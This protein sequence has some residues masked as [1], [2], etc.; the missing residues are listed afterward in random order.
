MALL[1]VLQTS[2]IARVILPLAVMAVI[3]VGIGVAT[4]AIPASDGQIHGCYTKAGGALRVI[5][6]EKNQSCKPVE[7]PISW[8]QQ[9]PQG[10]P[11]PP[12]PSGGDPALWAIVR[13]ADGNLFAGSHVA[14]SVRNFEGSYTIVFDQSIPGQGGGRLGCA[15]NVTPTS[16]DGDFTTHTRVTPIV[17]A[18]SA[19]T[20]HVE[21]YEG[22]TTVDQSFSLAVSC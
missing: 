6:V 21:N 17:Y 3:S 12:G 19:T 20:I 13:G 1:R 7:E 9:G 5:D 2:R 11:G 15:V 16:L 22:S 8:N 4:G 14:T 18:G 10:D